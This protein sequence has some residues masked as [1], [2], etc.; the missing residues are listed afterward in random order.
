[1]VPPSQ[2]AGWKGALKGVWKKAPKAGAEGR[3]PLWESS[4][5]WVMGHTEPAG[6][7]DSLGPWSANHLPLF[8]TLHF[9]SLCPLSRPL[10]VLRPP[11]PPSEWEWVGAEGR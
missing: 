9:P 2:G 10:S 11:A 8:T 6:V 5:G 3:G 7:E 4:M 1:M